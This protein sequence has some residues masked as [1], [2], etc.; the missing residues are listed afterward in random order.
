MI[1]ALNSCKIFL[2]DFSDND[3]YADKN[4]SVKN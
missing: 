4:E 2:I 1:Q 3:S